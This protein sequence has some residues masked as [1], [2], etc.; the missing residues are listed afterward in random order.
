MAIFTFVSILILI[1]IIR[2]PKLKIFLFSVPYKTT[3][4]FTQFFV[5]M[6]AYMLFATALTLILMEASPNGVDVMWILP[7]LIERI[8]LI[9]YEFFAEKSEVRD[10]NKVLD[11]NSEEFLKIIRKERIFVKNVSLLSLIVAYIMITVA[12][13]ADNDLL[14]LLFT[15]GFFYSLVAIIVLKYFI[16]RNFTKEQNN[17]TPQKQLT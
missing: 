9:I 11:K 14:P 15:I 10:G 6:P 8:I 16:Y 5:F 12:Q 3:N 4:I 7:L 2:M 17:P 13:I 1:I